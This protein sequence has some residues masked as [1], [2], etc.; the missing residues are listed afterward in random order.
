[1]VLLRFL[2]REAGPIKLATNVKIKGKQVDVAE[3]WSIAIWNERSI[4]H[5]L[6]EICA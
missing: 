5:K 1:M 3:N 4:S 2:E 6:E